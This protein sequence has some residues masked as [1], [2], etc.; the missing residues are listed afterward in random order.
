MANI[1]K[2]FVDNGRGGKGSIIV[3]SAGNDAGNTNGEYIDVSHYTIIVAVTNSNGSVT[4]YSNWG[5]NVLITTP[6]AKYAPSFKDGNYSTYYAD[7]MN[8]TSSSAPVTSGVIALMLEA[9][10]N[11]GWRDVQNI[12]AISAQHTGSSYTFSNGRISS[13]NSGYEVRDITG[14][15]KET[16]RKMTLATGMVED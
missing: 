8:G 2:K 1:F 11:L 4:S 3:K 16:W 9:N 12:L 7:N 14:L 6:E 15:I 13:G 10:A 5:S